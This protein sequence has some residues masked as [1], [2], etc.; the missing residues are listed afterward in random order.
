ME[1]EIE[2]NDMNEDVEYSF[3]AY[4]IDLDYEFDAARFFDFSRA[5]STWEE[6]Q[7]ELWFD[8]AGSYPPSPFM[9]RLVRREEILAEGVNASSKPKDAETLNLLESEFEIEADREISALDMDN[10][11]GKGQ[12]RGTSTNSQIVSVQNFWNLYQ[13]LPSGLTFYNHMINSNHSKTQPKLSTKPSFQRTSTLMKPTVSQLAKQNLSHQAGDSRS[14]KSF[15]GKTEKKTANLCGIESQATK[16]QKLEGGH[17]RK[18]VGS[19]QQNS[20]VHKAR[21]QDVTIGNTTQT[22]L[23]LTI[24]REPDLETANRAQRIRPKTSKEPESV[25]STVRRFK[26][27]PLN[28]KILEAPSLLLPKRST[29]HLPEFQ[30]F[31]LKT[32]ER[33]MQHTSADSKSTV[34]HSDK[35]QALQ[36]SSTSSTIKCGN[37][38][39]RRLNVSSASR[40]EGFEPSYCFKALPLNKKILSSRGDIGVSLNSKKETT[41]PME[42]NFQTEKRFH[43]NP[44]IELF[45]KLSLASETSSITGSESTFPGPTCISAKDSKENRW[46]FIK[47]EL[48]IKQVVIKNMSILGGRQIQHGTDGGKSNIG[49][50]SGISRSVGIR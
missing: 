10:R 15:I 45:N 39:P 34:H 27:L 13:N 18:V 25:T 8:T 6:R 48:E 36:K 33:A 19:E 29:P 28:R 7:A 5:E 40:Q 43:H 26:A 11:D 31:H 21:I 17:L 38:D 22:K 23:R 24:P 32:S 49:P 9:A 44:P 14:N 1:E 35:L 47:Q 20:F 2:D 16:R 42:F 12:D 3:T 41:V 4:E 37:R 46:G 50:V 30:E